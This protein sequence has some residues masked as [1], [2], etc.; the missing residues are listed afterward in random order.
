MKPMTQKL[1]IVACAFAGLAASSAAALASD[2]SYCGYVP[3][4]EWRS[5][6]EVHTAIE[7]RGYQVREIERDDGCYEVYVR[8][9][10]G[11]RYELYLHPRTLRVVKTERGW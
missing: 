6:S 2:D 8:D 11:K 7:A 9:Q 5:I 4:A 3:R 10:S 1:A